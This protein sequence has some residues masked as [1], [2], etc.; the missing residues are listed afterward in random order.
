V[1]ARGGL[2]GR[3]IRACAA[4]KVIS[5]N[6]AGHD[7]VDVAAATERG[8][9]VLVAAGANAQAVAEL[10]LG[11]MIAVAR[12]FAAHHASAQA[13]GWSKDRIGLQLAG[14]TLGLVGFGAISRKVGRFAA[15]IGMRVAFHDPHLPP[16]APCDGTERIDTLDDLLRRSQ[17]LSLHCPLTDTTRRLIGAREL[18]LLPPGALLVNTARGGLVDEAALVA[19]L[20]QGRLG[21]A[22]LDTFEAEPLP[23][24]SPLRRMAQVVVTPHVGAHAEEASAQVSRMA[25]QNLLRVLRGEPVDPACVVNPQVLQRPAAAAR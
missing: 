16:G 17:V 10:A 23:A 19:A 24:A 20:A 12:G 7:A 2:S 4:L 5:R 15:C 21:G 3:A 14:R 13:G 25:A 22:G 9:P 1:L 18:A 11:L 8:V 6:G